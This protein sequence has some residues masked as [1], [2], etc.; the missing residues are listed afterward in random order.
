MNNTNIDEA[1]GV[2]LRSDVIF[3]S[4]GGSSTRD[5][6][7]SYQDTGAEEIDDNIIRDMDCGEGFDRASLDLLGRQM[8]LLESLKKTK[9]PIVIVYIEGRPLNKV[10]ASENADAL[11][12]AYYPG[13]EGGLSIADVLFGDYNPEG[14]LLVS[15]PRYVG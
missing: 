10:W 2:A 5:F 12:T 4:A 6:K 11:L 7:T 1:V 15:V 3:V 9:K 8:E 14:L 13:Q